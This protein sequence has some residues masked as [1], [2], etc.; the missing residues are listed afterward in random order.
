MFLELV[1]EGYL[2]CVIISV[3]DRAQFVGRSW[4]L[5]STDLRARV[6]P[7][8][9]ARTGGG[10][11]QCFDHSFITLIWLLISPLAMP[12]AKDDDNDNVGRVG[13]VGARRAHRRA[14]HHR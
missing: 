9:K 7:I 8:D 1:R 12:L 13:R 6:P 14:D 5:G 3:H 2:V 10:G 11:G 4:I